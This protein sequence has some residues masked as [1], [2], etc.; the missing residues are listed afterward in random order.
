MQRHA[1]KRR[2][3]AEILRAAPG[4]Q[5]KFRHI[6]LESF[7]YMA[8]SSLD[9]PAQPYGCFHMRSLCRSIQKFADGFL[10]DN[11]K[12]D[13]LINNAGVFMPQ[14]RKTLEGFEVTL[15]T[16][17]FGPF[18]LTHLLMD[19]LKASAP[20]RVVWVVSSLETVGDI[21]WD[22]LK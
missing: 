8:T 21:K 5:V 9:V 15:A 17:Y 16:N 19:L 2:A 10:A 18:F 14:H 3:V 1:N 11:Q 12:L 22:D 20:S 7:R 13:C 6:D 4:S